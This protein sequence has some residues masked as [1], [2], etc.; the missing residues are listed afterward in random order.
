MDVFLDTLT[1]EWHN[2]VRLLPRLTVAIIV[3]ACS[4]IVGNLI[5][6]GVVGILARGD[7]NPTH[8]NFFRGLTKWLVV[9]IGLIIV[10]NIVGLKGLAASLVAGGGIT[11][12]VL[13]FAFREIGE[14]T[15]SEPFG[16]FRLKNKRYIS[17]SQAI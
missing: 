12:V 3:I 2:F 17:F 14:C 5:S 10:L 6:K 13:G 9:F 11:A 7:F 16:H 1:Q 4:I 8:R 15:S